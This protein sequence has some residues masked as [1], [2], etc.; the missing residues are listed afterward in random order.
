MLF[1]LANINKTKKVYEEIREEIK[2]QYVLYFNPGAS[3]LARS[4]LRFHPLI[5]K[6]KGHDDYDIRTI[7]GYY[8]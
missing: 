2:A 7:K 5:V 8:Y 6:V 4:F 3:G 1:P